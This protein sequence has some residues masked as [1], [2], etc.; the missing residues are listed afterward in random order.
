MTVEIGGY[1]VLNMYNG[2]Y[3][4]T[5]KT[6]TTLDSDIIFSKA[7]KNSRRIRVWQKKS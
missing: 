1:Y 5:P 4:F 7:P 3:K 6:L 2:T